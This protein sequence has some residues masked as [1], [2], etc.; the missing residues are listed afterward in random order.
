MPEDLVVQVPVLKE[1]L[2]LMKIRICELAGYEA[3]DVIGTLARKFGVQTYIYTGDRDSYQLV[4]ENTSVCYTRKGVSDI[5]ELS[6]E[7]FQSEVGLDPAQI[8]DL[9]ALM[10]DKSDN[11]PG[12][13]GVGEK[14][15]MQL[16]ADYGN[17]DE[18]TRI[19]ARSR[20]R[21]QKAYG[22]QRIR[23]F[24]PQTRH[25]RHGRARRHTA[26]GM[27]PADAFPAC[28]AGKIR[29]TR[30]PQPDL[31]PHFRRNRTTPAAGKR[32]SRSKK[33]SPLPKKRRKRYTRNLPATRSPCSGTT[34]VFRSART[35]A[36]TGNLSFPSGKICSTLGF[37]CTRCSRR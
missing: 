8:I 9:K 4:D 23:L 33:F 5:L 34:K 3:D 12:V 13:P 11:I 17:L 18:F 29:R 26:F 27:R 1:V 35:T 19:S 22:Q 31:S 24:F 25:D 2:S 7:N 21:S 16:L 36:P 30:F 32:G 28:G 37:F 14:S 10:G 20:G 15:A 6:A